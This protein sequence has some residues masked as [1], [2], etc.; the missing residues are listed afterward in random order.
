MS[1]CILGP[2]RQQGREWQWFFLS[3]SLSFW[4]WL[5]VVAARSSSWHRTGIY[6][7]SASSCDKI[8]LLAWKEHRGL[9]GGSR[10]LLTRPVLLCSLWPCSW[11]LSFQ[12][13]SPALSTTLS[14]PNPFLT[15]F[16]SAEPSIVSIWDLPLG[17][18]TDT[19]GVESTC[20][21]D[22]GEKS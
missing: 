3:L 19:Q 2:V 6:S 4:R 14:A 18:L 17:T 8:K 10:G 11:K 1:H 21:I 12:Y 22:F 15:S 20:P 16:S 13:E 9:L 7:G 5:E